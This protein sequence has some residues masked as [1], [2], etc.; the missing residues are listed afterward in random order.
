MANRKIFQL[1]IALQFKS[2]YFDSRVRSFLQTKLSYFAFN[3]I[4]KF[5]ALYQSEL[6][7]NNECFKYLLLTTL[8]RISSLRFN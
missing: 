6:L 3:Q 4:I 1:A 7:T 8:E 5:L 2:L